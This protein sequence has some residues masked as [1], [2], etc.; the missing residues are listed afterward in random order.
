VLAGLSGLPLDGR[1]AT[2]DRRQAT[3]NS[4]QVLCS[5]E[6]ACSPHAAAVRP[7]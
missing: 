1:R 3:V 5:V 4:A 6:C 7:G 2:G